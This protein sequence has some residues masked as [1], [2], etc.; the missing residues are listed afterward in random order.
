MIKSIIF[1]DNH[2]P[3]CCRTINSLAAHDVKKKFA[4]APLEG[5]TA[6][7]MFFGR[8]SY[9]RTLNTVILVEQPSGRIWV[10]GR[11]VFRIFWLLGGKWKSIGW[12]YEMPFVDA[13]Y[14]I[15]A[16]HRKRE[17]DLPKLTIHLLP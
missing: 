4:F 2:C 3:L 13:V 9:L 7:K 11:A 12:L 17:G 6:E 14:K 15:I 1:F 10:R 16:K 5:K 8:L